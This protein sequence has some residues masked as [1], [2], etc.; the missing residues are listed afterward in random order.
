VKSRRRASSAWVPNTLSRSTRPCSSCW[1]ALSFS[2]PASGTGA[3]KVETSTVSGPSITC[4]RR[5]RRPMI[6]ARRKSGLICSGR[7]SVAMSKSLGVMPSSRSRTAPPTTYAEKP[8]SRSTAHTLAAAG[9][10][11]SRAMPCFSRGTRNTASEGRPR[12][13]R[14]NLLIIAAADSTGAALLAQRAHRPAPAPRFRGQLCVGVD[15][16]RPRDPLEER[17][18]VVRVAVEGAFGELAE[19]PAEAG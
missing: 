6:S 11:D 7:A 16:H 19:A 14:M 15:G 17:E 2:A 8:A 9:L 18:V 1:W 10:M 4:T 3:R 13:R 5:K 12:T